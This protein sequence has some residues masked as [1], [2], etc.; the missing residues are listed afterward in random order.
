MENTTMSSAL[1]GPWVDHEKKV[2]E[3]WLNNDGIVKFIEFPVRIPAMSHRA[4]H[5]Y[6]QR[7]HSPNVMNVTAFSQ[8]MRKYNTSHV[9]PD[10]VPGLPGHYRQT[11]AFEGAA[12]VWI[13]SLDDVEGWLAHPLYAELIQPDEPRFIRQDGSMEIVV[14]KEENLYVPDADMT[15]TGLAKLYLLLKRKFGL[16]HD[17]FHA[18]ISAH[19]ESI[20]GHASLRSLLRKLVLSHKL[21]EPLPAGIPFADIDAVAELWFFS[22]KH[23]APF[24]ADAAYMSV[25]QP[26]EATVIDVTAVRALVAKMLVVH[27]EFSF[28]SSTMQ[29]LSF[30]WSD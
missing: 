11:T 14:V 25:V 24:F 22:P 13:N 26:L 29:P 30:D 27:D 23:I 20:L 21:R 15:E 16:D 19:L 18:A 4:F 12:E 3:P 7:H 28:Q 9:Y 6:W 5:L 1:P 17:E 2:V 10:K 8:F